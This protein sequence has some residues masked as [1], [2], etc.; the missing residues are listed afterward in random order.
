[1]VIV[2]RFMLLNAIAPSPERGGCDGLA[3]GNRKSFTRAVAGV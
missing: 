3:S 1:M 2:A